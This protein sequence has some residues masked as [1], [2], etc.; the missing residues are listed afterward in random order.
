MTSYL[1]EIELPGNYTEEFEQRIPHQ[2]F[3][4]NKLMEK[5]T[6]LSYSL[7]AD[8]TKLWVTALAASKIQLR[9]MITSMPLYDY[10]VEYMIHDLMFSETTQPAMPQP[11]LN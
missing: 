4:V 7:A 6:I 9:N 10:F 11:S 8:R 5:G 3:M 1:V 2:R